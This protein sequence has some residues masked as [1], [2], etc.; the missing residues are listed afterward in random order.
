MTAAAN[1]KIYA[2]RKLLKE[3]GLAFVRQSAQ[4]V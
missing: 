4:S 1:A 2:K 3:S